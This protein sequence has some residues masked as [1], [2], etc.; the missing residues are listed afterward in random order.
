L[1]NQVNS[2]KKKVKVRALDS[3]STGD[4]PET[5]N[6]DETSDAAKP[7]PG[8]RMPMPGPGTAPVVTD[9]GPG[10]SQMLGLLQKVGGIEGLLSIVGTIRGFMDTFQRIAP[11]FKRMFGNFGKR[12][13]SKRRRSQYSPFKGR[14]RERFAGKKRVSRKLRA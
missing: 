7:F 6:P 4:T 8:D 2:Y 10:L 9:S 11:M 14:R 13:T 1:R 5:E 3:A 12:K